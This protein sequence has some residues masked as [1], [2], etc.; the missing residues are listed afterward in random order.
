MAGMMRRM[1]KR[2]SLIDQ[3][4]R[5]FQEQRASGLSVAAFCRRA[6]VPPASF[7]TWRRKLRVE[8]S[9]RRDAVA[10]AE[11]KISPERACET[12]GIEL[13]LPG[14][15]RVVVRPGFDR[16]TLLDLL[17]ALEEEA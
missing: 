13:R 6:Q 9:P 11:V 8:D 12:D 15:R 5:T 17:A 14:Q 2:T 4:R 7:Y 3:W 16:Q 1:R 10:F